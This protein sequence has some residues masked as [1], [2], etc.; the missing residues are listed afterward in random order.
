[1]AETSGGSKK[2]L[3][4]MIILVLL[5]SAGAAAA[6]YMVIDQRD[7]TA[8][9]GDVA[10][11][12]EP[13]APIFMSI[14]PFTVNLADDRHGSRLLYTG[15]TLRVGN[16]ASKTILEEHMPQVRSRLL[17]LLS[18]KQAEELTSSE[19]KQQLAQAIVD[20]L[21]APLT[22][23]QPPLDLREVLFTEFIVQ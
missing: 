2:L 13:E 7:D 18:G 8:A 23:N 16:E 11:E 17:M 14:E 22:E 6:I 12:M 4:I 15:I 9:E 3:W 5:S 19:G 1:M 20:R 21:N 10:Q